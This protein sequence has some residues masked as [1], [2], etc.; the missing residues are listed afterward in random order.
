MIE[1]VCISEDKKRKMAE[2][3]TD[4]E[5]R[6]TAAQKIDVEKSKHITKLEKEV[7]SNAQTKLDLETCKANLE[8]FRSGDYEKRHCHKT[9]AQMG[10]N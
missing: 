9:W 4:L 2:T 8:H 10:W 7:Q 1:K 6:L 5:K 3:V